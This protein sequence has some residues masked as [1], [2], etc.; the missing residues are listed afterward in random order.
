MIVR[1]AA[2]ANGHCRLCSAERLP[3]KC[4]KFV[5]VDQHL[6]IHHASTAYCWCIPVPLDLPSVLESMTCGPL[7][8]Y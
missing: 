3:A 6:M 2:V 5:K 7:K 1:S 4:F 8:T